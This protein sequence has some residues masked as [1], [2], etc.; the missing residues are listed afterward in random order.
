M[1][2]T[3]SKDYKRLYD[4]YK[5]KYADLSNKMS[6]GGLNDECKLYDYFD[7][8]LSTVIHSTDNFFQFEISDIS[9]EKIQEDIVTIKANLA[10]ARANTVTGSQVFSKSRPI[11]NDITYNEWL[12]L[13]STYQV[14]SDDMDTD[15]IPIP[16]SD[17]MGKEN[18]DRQNRII[19]VLLDDLDIANVSLDVANTARKVV[20]VSLKLR[21]LEQVSPIDTVDIE[22]SKTNLVKYSD[23]LNKHKDKLNEH[24]VRVYKSDVN[25]ADFIKNIRVS[26]LQKDIITKKKLTEAIIQKDKL[27][28]DLNELQDTV[29]KYQNKHSPIERTRDTIN[30]MVYPSHK[31]FREDAI[32]STIVDLNELKI[33]LANQETNIAFLT[34]ENEEINTIIDNLKTRNIDIRTHHDI[35]TAKHRLIYCIKYVNPLKVGPFDI[36]YTDENKQLVTLQLFKLDM[37]DTTSMSIIHYIQRSLPFPNGRDAKIY[38]TILRDTTNNI[39][40]LSKEDIKGT[41]LRFV[42]KYGYI[43]LTSFNNP[44]INNIATLKTS[45]DT[46]YNSVY[47]V[48]DTYAFG[49]NIAK[50][51]KTVVYTDDDRARYKIR[52]NSILSR[53]EFNDTNNINAIKDILIKSLDPNL[54]EPLVGRYNPPEHNPP[55]YINKYHKV[56]YCLFLVYNFH[57]YTQ[58]F[59]L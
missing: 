6:G 38:M 10:K 22:T 2:N 18:I 13:A 49:N 32:K 20:N 58:Y 40:F 29:D 7:Y 47:L 59:Q 48:K 1:I 33:D 4:K 26:F 21:E 55:D 14:G 30:G 50:S 23:E 11:N 35:N 54:Y 53:L 39:C 9:V 37:I 44:I 52:H 51:N 41:L 17:I 43:H 36:T 5:S 45:F 8:L 34:S 27:Q 12:T 56:M 15:V 31:K 25:Y 19:S 46:L 42:N 24:N 28:T 3:D 57:Y 16:M